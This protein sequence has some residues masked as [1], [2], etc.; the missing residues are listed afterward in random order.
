MTK[1]IIPAVIAGI[2]I[3]AVII[4]LIIMNTH[5]SLAEI[6]ENNDCQELNKFDLRMDATYGYDVE[7]AKA[8]ENISDELFSKAQSLGID[9]AFDAVSDM[10][11]DNTSENISN[12]ELYRN[13]GEDYISCG[14][15]TSCGKEIEGEAAEI[16][17]NRD[18]N[19]FVEWYENNKRFVDD[20]YFEYKNDIESYN[21]YCKD[22][23]TVLDENG[24]DTEEQWSIYNESLHKGSTQY[25]KWDREYR[26]NYLSEIEESLK[27]S[28]SDLNVIYEFDE[29]IKGEDCKQ[30]MVWYENNIDHVDVLDSYDDLED[31]M[32]HA[33]GCE[34]Q[35]LT[36]ELRESNPTEL[37]PTEATY[38]LFWILQ[39]RQCKKYDSWIKIYGEDF[40]YVKDKLTEE[41][42][43]EYKRC[44]FI[45]N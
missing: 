5:P 26:Y 42:S 38:D 21:E 43:S 37:D 8:Q 30:F 28:K 36:D 31:I 7:K 17:K 18:C 34:I 4:G 10:H 14:I 24:I 6:V 16:I 15:S 12:E 1:I 23:D 19:R 41:Y 3:V 29:I 25:D 44:K 13:G 33:W 27:N 11:D 35:N 32:T 40:D 20:M 22:P 2:V 9:C 39:D 45:N